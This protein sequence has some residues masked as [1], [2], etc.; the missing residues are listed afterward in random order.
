ME[1]EKTKENIKSI[2]NKDEKVEIKKISFSV[3]SNIVIDFMNSH[4]KDMNMLK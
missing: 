1:I 4:P 3:L 2:Y